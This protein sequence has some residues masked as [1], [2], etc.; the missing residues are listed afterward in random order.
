MPEAVR[1]LVEFSQLKSLAERCG[2]ESIHR[3]GGAA[4]IQFHPGA[5]IDP[6]R[7]MHLVSTT[8]QAQFTPAG[9][10]R[11]PLPQGGAAALL[12]FLRQLL[13]GLRG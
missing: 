7:L 10:L 12:A 1:L 11:I 2:I 4:L 5:P 13:E 6:Q 9:V 8:P 3:R